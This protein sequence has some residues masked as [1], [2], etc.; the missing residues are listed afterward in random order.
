MSLFQM[1]FPPGLPPNSTVSLDLS[2]NDLG[3]SSSSS[4]SSLSS[5]LSR[6]PSLLSLDLS[7][8]GLSSLLPA[9]VHYKLEKLVRERKNSF[10]T[11][12]L[13]KYLCFRREK[14][15]EKGKKT[16]LFFFL[17]SFFL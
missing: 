16:F 3:S 14:S 11:L 8:N 7:R 9:V 15:I 17:F 4:S 12:C 2:G 1:S 5:S 10:K 6:L 13:G